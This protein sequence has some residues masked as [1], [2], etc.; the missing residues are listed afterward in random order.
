MSDKV[1]LICAIAYAVIFTI[2][3]I[4]FIYFFDKS[5]QEKINDARVEAEK[6]RI[7]FDAVN[8]E[9]EKLREMM[10][11][12]NDAISRVIDIIETSQVKHEERIQTIENDPAAADWLVCE[13]P[14]SVR[15]AFRDYCADGND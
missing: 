2:M 5:A 11:K 1:K 9:N 12:T 8:G 4:L 3:S 15:D 7:A 14:D 6:T 13:L 10:V